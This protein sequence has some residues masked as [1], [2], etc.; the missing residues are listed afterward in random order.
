MDNNILPSANNALPVSNN[1][2]PAA[3]NMMPSNVMPSMSNMQPMPYNNIMPAMDDTPANVMPANVMPA[4]VMPANVMPA[5][6]M[7]VEQLEKMYP[8]TYDIIHPVAEETCEKCLAKNSPAY[9]PTKKELDSMVD[10]IYSK[11]ESKVENNMKQ[12]S[13]ERQF[14][15]SSRRLLRDF[16][17]VLLISSFIRRR[18][19]FFRQDFPWYDYGYGRPLGCPF[20]QMF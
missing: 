5:N 9:V 19:F 20:Y 16:I 3:N 6:V 14:F 10:E 12:S 15:G 18:P 1:V 2:F 17:T 4:N 13:N 11:V 8:K 7:P